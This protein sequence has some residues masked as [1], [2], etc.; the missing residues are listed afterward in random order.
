MTTRAH[1]LFSLSV[2][3]KFRHTPPTPGYPENMRRFF[4]PVDN[5]KGALTQIVSSAQQSLVLAMYGFD[6][7]DLAHMIRLKLADPSCHVQITLDATQAAGAHEKLL[8]GREKFPATSIAIGHSEHGA[9]MHLKL[10]VIDGWL[11]VSGSTNWSDSAEAKQDN[12]LTVIADPLFAAE[13]RARIDAIHTNM[14]AKQRE[15][16]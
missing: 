5:V 12:E 3:D 2:L 15:K 9:I 13:S 14:L 8:L 4:S 7:D 6:D 1:P 10:M 11:T 16:R